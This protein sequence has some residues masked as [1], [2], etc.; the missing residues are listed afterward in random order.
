MV[1][2]LTL[3]GPLQLEGSQVAA[4][5][6]SRCPDSPCSTLFDGE[7][8]PSGPV[9][10]PQSGLRSLVQ[11][12]FPPGVA[13]LFRNYGPGDLKSSRRPL[14]TRPRRIRSPSQLRCGNAM[15]GGSVGTADLT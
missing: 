1:V 12:L 14:W 10:R 4:T 15:L 11:G 13:I 8:L 2:E 3:S 6:T 7:R 5:A 9:C